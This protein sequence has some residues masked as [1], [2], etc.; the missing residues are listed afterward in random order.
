MNG[1]AA[2]TGTPILFGGY[3]LY[4]YLPQSGLFENGKDADLASALAF[5]GAFLFLCGGIFLIRNLKY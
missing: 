4:K 3:L 5:L 2:G 1:R